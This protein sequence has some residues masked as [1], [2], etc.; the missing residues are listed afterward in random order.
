MEIGERVDALE[1]GHASVDIKSILKEFGF[2][3]GQAGVKA[4]EKIPLEV[5]MEVER[6]EKL[7]ARYDRLDY[8]E[9]ICKNCGTRNGSQWRR[10]NETGDVFLVCGNC[11]TVA[12]V[13]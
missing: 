2:T 7:Q 12:E 1:M 8:A 13:K 4:L 9:F 5:Q 3:V 11:D 6:I 10:D